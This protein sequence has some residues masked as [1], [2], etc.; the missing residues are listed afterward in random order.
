M[1]R[2]M[3]VEDDGT[4]ACLLSGHLQK[5]GF[6]AFVVRDFENVLDCF[7][8]EQPHLVLLDISLPFYNGYYWCA[9][10][11]K[12]SSV[13]ILFLSS[14][15]ENMDIVMAVNMGGDDFVTKPF[16]MEVLTAKIQALL[17]RAYSYYSD[18]L[19]LEAAGAILDLGT[20]V[21][22]H[23]GQSAELTKNELKILRLL[24]ENKNSAVSREQLMQALWDSEYFIDGNTLTVNIN[25]LRK[26]LADLGLPDLISTRKGVG[27]VVVS[28]E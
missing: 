5:W 13:P 1:Y 20:G 7:E 4:I 24:M 16:A 9:Q 28:G 14:H 25:R 10:I 22:T 27:Y 21:L 18:R 26:K 23:G 11:R 3:I 2:I 17:R 8:H 19:T 12:K 6:E 15:T